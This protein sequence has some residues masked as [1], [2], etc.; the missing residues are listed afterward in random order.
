MELRSLANQRQTYIELAESKDDLE[1]RETPTISISL[2]WSSNSCSDSVQ[3]SVKGDVT[4]VPNE[5]SRHGAPRRWKVKIKK[6]WTR[7]RLQATTSMKKQKQHDDD[8]STRIGI[9]ESP[10]D[11]IVK[12]NKDATPNKD[13]KTCRER[14]RLQQSRVQ[15]KRK[16]RLLTIAEDEEFD[17]TGLHEC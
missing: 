12:K 8:Y 15:F 9:A 2:S 7:L 16:L 11:Y 14:N 6:F 10:R 1:L 13:R 4:E 3:A 5:N 17:D